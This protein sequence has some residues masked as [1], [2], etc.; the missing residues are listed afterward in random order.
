M[1]NFKIL[2]SYLECFERASAPLLSSESPPRWKYDVFLSF[3]G[4]D[5]RKGFVSH[6]YH[7]LQRHGITTFFDVRELE[8]GA[9]IPLGL[10]CAIKES[11]TAIVVLS[12]NYASSKWCL[13]EL[14]N[15]VQCMKATN[16]ILPV[17]YDVNPSDVGNQ[18]G[19]FA[20]AFPE[21]DKKFI[22]TEDKTKVTQWKADLKL[23]SNLFGL[24][25]RNF[26]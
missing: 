6:L 18:R 5:T 9:S 23:V 4:A 21:H 19:S 14:T 25:L 24:H 16:S 3:M 8:G 17:F 20:E 13:D 26:K 11:N 22:S 2:N 10:P 12:P 7:Q 1:S 15:I